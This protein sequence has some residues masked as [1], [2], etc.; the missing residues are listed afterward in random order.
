MI[1]FSI[2]LEAGLDIPVTHLDSQTTKG[3]AE[4]KFLWM[5][6]QNVLISQMIKTEMSY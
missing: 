1:N 3:K 6:F 5:P 2:H 4:D